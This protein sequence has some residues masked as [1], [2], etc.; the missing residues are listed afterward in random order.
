MAALGDLTD[1]E[2]RRYAH[3]GLLPRAFQLRDQLPCAYDAVYVTLAEARGEAL[4]TFDRRLANAP[5]PAVLDRR[6]ARRVA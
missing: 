5:G 2:V 3:R 4:L 1:L 6:S